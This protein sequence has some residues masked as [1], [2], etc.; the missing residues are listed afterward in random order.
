MAAKDNAAKP[1]QPAPA[2][3]PRDVVDGIPDRAA[4]RPL[5]KYLVIALVFLAWL[6]FLLYCLFAY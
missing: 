3:P 2:L 1:P 5:W 6:A 4:R